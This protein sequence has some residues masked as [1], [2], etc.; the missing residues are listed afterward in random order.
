[1]YLQQRYEAEGGNHAPKINK[2]SQN[3]VR[4]VAP[5]VADAERR[6]QA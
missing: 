6:R 4:G 5:L 2:S 1:M 3:M